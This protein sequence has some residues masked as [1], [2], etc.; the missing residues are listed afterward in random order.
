M[1]LMLSSLQFLCFQQGMAEDDIL[2]DGT[3][4]LHTMWLYCNHPELETLME[5]VDYPTDKNLREAG[6]VQTRLVGG[7]CERQR[8]GNL[9]RSARR[10]CAYRNWRVT[11]MEI[12]P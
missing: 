6:M 8:L 5:Q 10:G 7:H 1:V 4:L 9:S 3:G 11:D 12:S 2:I